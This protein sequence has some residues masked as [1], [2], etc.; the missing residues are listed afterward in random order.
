MSIKTKNPTVCYTH[1]KDNPCYVV[2]PE[3]FTR[4]L[5]G[6]RIKSSTIEVSFNSGFS[7]E[8]QS[9]F[10]YAID[11]WESLIS[12]P[13]TIKI[14]A[15][16]S[17]LSTN[18]LGGALYTSA[19][20][21]FDGAQKL[22][23]FYP[24]ALAEKITG[25]NL[26]GNDHEIFIQF[27][28]NINWNYDPNATPASGQFDLVSV[29]L[30]EIGHGLGF[31]G[32]FSANATDGRFGLQSTGLPMIYD[33][34]IENGGLENL[35][36]VY[37]SPSGNLRTQLISNDLFFNSATS[38]RPKLYAPGTFSSGSSI[39]HLDE[40][41]YNNTL[42]ALMTPQIAP[43]EKI[44]NPGIAWDMLKDMGWEMVK[45][46]HIALTD[47]ENIADPFIVTVHVDAD[48]GYSSRNQ[49]LFYTT[50]GTTFTTVPLTPT[51]TPNELTATIPSTGA[52]QEYGYY[53]SIAD[54]AGR[55]FVRPGKTLRKLNTEKQNVFVFA[56]GPD[57]KAPIIT[58]SAKPFLL[59]SET[60]LK[61]DAVVT[62]NIGI[63]LVMVE[64]FIN[65]IPQTPQQLILTSPETDS[66]Y[67]ITLAIG[68]LTRGD[69]VKYRI[70]ATDNSSNSNQSSSP[71]SDFYILNVVGLEPTQDSY[72][73]TFNTTSNDFF[74]N[75]FSIT[76]PSGFANPAIH[77]S[78]PYPEGNGS[79]ND[80]LNFVYQLKIPIKIKSNDA[81]LRFDEIV[82][83]EPGESGTVFG[84]DQFWDYVV[85]EGSTD[86]GI[87]WTPVADGYD[88]RANSVWLTRY[89]SAISDNN[90]TAVGDPTLYRLRSFDL[91]NRFNTA[92]EV[93]IRF[94]LF[95]DP[96]AAG[97][98]WAIDNLK[99]QIDDTPPRILHDHIDYLMVGDD[100]LEV[101]TR[102]SDASGIESLRVEYRINGGEISTQEFIVNPPA[103]QYTFSLTGLSSL[104]VND[105]VE[106]RV[107][108]KDSIGNES[109]FPALFDFIKVPIVSFNSSITTYTQ[110][111]NTPTT[112][113]VGNFFS[114]EQ[115]ANFTDGAIH[116]THFYPTGAG[117]NNTSFF[118]TTLK[119]PIT[120]SSSN[121]IMRFDEIVI[122]EGHPAGV[123][124]G[125]PNFK[126]YVIVDGSKDA[127]STWMPIIEGYDFVGGLASWGSAFNGGLDG[128]SEM[129]R[130][131]LIDLT[132]NGNFQ[133]GNEVIIRFRLFSNET[134]NG[135][136]W[137][138]DNLYIQDPI[139]SIETE[140]EKN[141][142]IYPNPIT[143]NTLTI[144]AESNSSH[145]SEI[146]LITIHGKKIFATTV[147]HENGRLFY[148]L[149]VSTVPAGLYLVR[150]QGSSG[151]KIIRK[152]IKSN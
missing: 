40:T 64:Y 37:Q 121:S 92:D 126:D 103:N 71:A 93:V 56:T 41:T 147:D 135:W 19:F 97:W 50:D 82:L 78:H 150:I 91:L 13:V 111:F 39:S 22:S 102:A 125:S 84:S 49:N 27:N 9:A 2:P 35:I 142:K 90:S 15:Y 65:D 29:V 58:H 132:A 1:T 63:A 17:P 120:I 114:V 144:Y 104:A 31:A 107:L 34:P 88:S 117:L 101:S 10:N 36:R 124:F 52:S 11:I 67:S 28:S 140:L 118:S 129:F 134:V 45:I 151:E 59:E 57:N 74:G 139:T 42:H 96:F 152:F 60:S 94:R 76:Q 128:S 53:I 141:F 116:S 23:V 33:V 26:N 32:T 86:G 146:V 54:N 66:I 12:S 110:N 99:I 24:V 85:V 138:I 80:E 3:E 143:N 81:I 75:G 21:N 136:G 16:W 4:H 48:N 113:F 73:N 72:A 18:V 44:H 106:Y 108:A 25:R 119:K 149:D 69:E 109:K 77:S 70:V 8:A 68:T 38:S 105:L 87:T 115:P 122:V 47:R 148:Q 43:A 5:Q 130:T 127:G 100:V 112:D 6:A 79:P 55:E 145:H 46:N 98:G 62:D 20:A 123:T 14:D 7:A 89:N 61:L 83:V 133:P 30:H 131:R 95:S 137:A 51:G